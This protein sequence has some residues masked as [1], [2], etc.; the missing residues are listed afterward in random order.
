MESGGNLEYY[1]E[2]IE[3]IRKNYHLLKG[4]EI[5]TA[6]FLSWWCDNYHKTTASFRDAVII[7][8]E[9]RGESDE[10]RN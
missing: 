3:Y 8:N 2:G 6:T 10:N 4:N 9:A 1:A 7:W 5:A